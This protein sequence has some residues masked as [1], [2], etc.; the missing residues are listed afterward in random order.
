[1][2]Y[3][4]IIVYPSGAVH[5]EECVSLVEVGVHMH[6][7]MQRKF[8]HGIPEGSVTFHVTDNTIKKEN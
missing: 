6:H 8:V 2:D 7:R 3:T 1:M 4:L 5:K